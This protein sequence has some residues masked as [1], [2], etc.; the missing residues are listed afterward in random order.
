MEFLLELKTNWID[1][2]GNHYSKDWENNPYLITYI[3]Q[4]SV[5]GSQTLKIVENTAYKPMYFEEKLH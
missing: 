5:K 4:L 2:K 1:E 3:T